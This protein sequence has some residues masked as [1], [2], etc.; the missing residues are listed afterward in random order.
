MKKLLLVLSFISIGLI[1]SSC[2]GSSNKNKAEEEIST[3]VVKNNKSA[4]GNEDKP[5]PKL[6]FEETTHDFGKIIRG[7]KLKYRFKFKNTG[8]ADLIISKVSTSCGCTASNYPRRP[9]K[10]GEESYIDVVFNSAHKR[11]KQHKTVTILANTQPNKTVLHITG[12]VVMP[13]KDK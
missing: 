7:E 11:G 2:N 8:N 4:E 1:F 9:V 3:D 6:V 12:T 13:E 5:M 10:P